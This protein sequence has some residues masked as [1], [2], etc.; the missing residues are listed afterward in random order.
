MT[1]CIQELYLSKLRHARKLVVR[2]EFAHQ[3]CHFFPF[4]D[5]MRAF[6]PIKAVAPPLKFDGCASTSLVGI[7]GEFMRRYLLTTGFAAIMLIAAPTAGGSR[8]DTEDHTVA[9][10]PVAVE[11]VSFKPPY[12]RDEAA[13]VLIG[14]AMIGLAAAVRRAAP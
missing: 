2:V 3:V 4:F 14:T 10:A 1:Y 8:P 7:H 13:M 11:R 5:A 6:F 12:V 9:T